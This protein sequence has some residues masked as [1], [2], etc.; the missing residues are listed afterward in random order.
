MT[1]FQDDKGTSEDTNKESIRYL[2][3]TFD[4][5]YNVLSSRFELF[6]D[7]IDEPVKLEEV[8]RINESI[9]E[10]IPFGDTFLHFSSLKNLYISP[11]FSSLEMTYVFDKMEV[12][13]EIEEH[14]RKLM[15]STPGEDAF[16]LAFGVHDEQ[17]DVKTMLFLTYSGGVVSI[18]ILAR[19]NEKADLYKKFQ[20]AMKIHEAFRRNKYL[21]LKPT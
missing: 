14:L 15:S 18:S 21:R 19:V 17:E 10:P 11:G 13:K 8:A 4:P 16:V 2:I 1:Q 9:L 5:L 3:E 7:F 20:S 6:P 12:P